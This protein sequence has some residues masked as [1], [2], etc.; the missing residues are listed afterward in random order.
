MVF[1]ALLRGINVGGHNSIDMKQLKQTFLRAGMT[2]VSTYINSGN[3]V[4]VCHDLEEKEIQHKLENAIKKDFS[5]Y[6]RV[7]LLNEIDYQNIKNHLPSYWINDTTMK[8]DVMFLWTP[9]SE[10]DFIKK[11]V[12]E[13]ILL[14]KA[15]LWK[16]DRINQTKSGQ[17]KLVGSKLYA[18]MTIRNVNTFRKIDELIQ[19][20][21]ND[22]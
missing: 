9:A 13:I 18:Q 2:H 11:D 16:V 19:K 7:L 15:I 4:F 10:S 12:D 8:A 14:D 6:I 22:A 3:V 17:M 5:L 20:T 21:K 1:V